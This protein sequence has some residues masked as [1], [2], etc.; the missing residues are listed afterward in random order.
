MTLGKR[1]TQ[2]LA[3]EQIEAI[4]KAEGWAALFANRGKDPE[5]KVKHFAPR[6]RGAKDNGIVGYELTQTVHR[7]FESGHYLDKAG[8]LYHVTDYPNNGPV[9]IV[10]Y[11]DA[12]DSPPWSDETVTAILEPLT[13][14][15]AQLC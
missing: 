3:R 11:Y 14:L 13:K 4:C 1:L 5:S 2:E 9:C 6:I 12:D 7:H 10:Q 15:R 8:N